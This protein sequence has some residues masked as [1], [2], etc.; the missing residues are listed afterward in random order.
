[1]WRGQGRG[2]RC[3]W[4]EGGSWASRG[5]QKMG[6]RP[7]WRRDLPQSRPPGAGDS[8]PHFRDGEMEAQ[9]ATVTYSGP[10]SSKVRAKT[11]TRFVP[12]YRQSVS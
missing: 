11:H 9:R 6:K 1:M 7:P 10:H 2:P 4:E 8:D 12:L 3:G 5:V